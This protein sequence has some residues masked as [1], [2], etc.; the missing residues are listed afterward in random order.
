MSYKDKI[1]K[2]RL[3]AQALLTLQNFALSSPELSSEKRQDIVRAIYIG[4]SLSRNNKCK[5]TQTY[6]HLN[7][8]YT[9]LGLL[10]S[11][12]DKMISHP[13]KAKEVKKAICTIS[14][15]SAWA[16]SYPNLVEYYMKNFRISMV[17]EG[18]SKGIF[19]PRTKIIDGFRHHIGPAEDLVLL[20][21]NKFYKKYQSR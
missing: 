8:Q 11:C 18:F 21:G 10:R 17:P 7:Y 6:Y 9:S 14:A 3:F 13:E 16:S 1:L 4:G 2:K 20:S 12:L 19:G 15:L 5:K